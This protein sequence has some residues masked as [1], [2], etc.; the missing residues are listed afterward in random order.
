[1]FAGEARRLKATHGLELTR[2][3]CGAG[4]WVL[5]SDKSGVCEEQRRP[6]EAAVAQSQA[7]GTVVTM[8]TELAALW[9][10]SSAR[11]CPPG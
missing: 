5:V 4:R 8:R 2:G 10:R 6:F 3:A 7:L 1:M 11:S 9:E